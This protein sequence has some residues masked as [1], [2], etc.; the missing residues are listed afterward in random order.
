M[1]PVAAFTCELCGL[2]FPSVGGGKCSACKRMLCASH[3]ARPD[4][5]SAAVATQLVCDECRAVKA[6][7]KRS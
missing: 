1:S 4:D 2:D 5:Q 7:S 6:G 3:F